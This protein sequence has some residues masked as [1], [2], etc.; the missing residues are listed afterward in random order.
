MRVYTHPA[1]LAH[2]TGPGHAERPERLAAVTDALR[3]ALPTLDWHEAPRASRGQLLRAHAATLL[4][5]VL[6]TRPA[7]RI[8][9]DPDTVLVARPPPKPP[10]ARPAPPWP[11]S[12]RC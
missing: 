10:C 8:M 9:L 2:D 3:G 11:P 4:A 1:C 6:E 7:A 12:M 5:T